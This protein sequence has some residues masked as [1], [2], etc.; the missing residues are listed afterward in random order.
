MDISDIP[1]NMNIG[2]ADDLREVP[3]DTDQMNQGVNFLKTAACVSEISL[4]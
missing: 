3:I 4:V 1:F 2:I